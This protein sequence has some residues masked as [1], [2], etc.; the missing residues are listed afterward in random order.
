MKPLFLLT[1]ILAILLQCTAMTAGGVTPRINGA[2]GLI[3]GG[4]LGNSSAACS[5]DID[6]IFPT[7]RP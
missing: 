6:R 5:D 2:P 4:E 1:A 7:S 3:L